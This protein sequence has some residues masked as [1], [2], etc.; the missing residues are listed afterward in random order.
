METNLEVVGA[1]EH[2]FPAHRDASDRLTIVSRPLTPF[3]PRTLARKIVE[4]VT[5][6]ERYAV[7]RAL[8]QYTL[9]GLRKIGHRPIYDP[10]M[11]SQCSRH[12]V[13]MGCEENLAWA[14]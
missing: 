4:K 1:G 9:L 6:R 11:R 2:S 13:I 3:S 7:H 12:A 5:G 8:M 14:V 10:V